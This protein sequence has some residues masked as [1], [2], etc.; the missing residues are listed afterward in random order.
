MDRLAGAGTGDWTDGLRKP[1]CRFGARAEAED[2]RREGA[3]A[4]GCPDQGRRGRGLPV[5]ELR[6]EG[7]DVSRGVQGQDQARAVAPG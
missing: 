5:P 3:G 4:L 1:E 2:R 7:G 6:L